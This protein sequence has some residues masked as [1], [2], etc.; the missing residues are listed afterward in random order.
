MFDDR[1]EGSS[2]RVRGK[3]DLF[4]NAWNTVGLIP[5]CAGKT[6]SISVRTAAPRAHPRVC[7]EN[8]AAEAM[9][10][11]VTGSSP[12]VRGKRAASRVAKPVRGLIP[13]CAGKTARN[14]IEEMNSGA[15]PRV[16]GENRVGRATRPGLP[17]SSPRVRGKLSRSRSITLLLGLI[18]ACAGKTKRRYHRPVNSRAH[19]RVC[20]ENGG[21]GG[22][23]PRYPGSSPRVRGK[24]S[25]I[26]ERVI[27]A[28]LIPACAG[29]TTSMK[30]HCSLNPAHPRVC[31]E[32]VSLVVVATLVA[33]S[34]PRVRGKRTGSR[35][36]CQGSGLIPACAGKT[37]RACM[38]TPGGMAHPRVCGENVE[39]RRRECL[40]AGSSPRV[41]GKRGT[42]RRGRLR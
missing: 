14:V 13:A 32:N 34:S 42:C 23:P 6:G 27:K 3:Q 29:K 7:G 2:P 31:G 21:A 37:L 17:G 15:H 5:A 1:R 26:D 16:C 19:P 36:Q 33:G 28:R 39:D 10:N 38:V 22:S 11:L 12:R 30:Q 25:T 9:E 18:P 41:R 20:G 4:G 8:P 24:R 35:D 40:L